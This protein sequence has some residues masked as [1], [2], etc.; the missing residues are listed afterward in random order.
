MTLVELNVQT[1]SMVGMLRVGPVLGTEVAI[2]KIGSTLTA[3]I[4]IATV[5]LVAGD[6]VMGLIGTR[7][8]TGT[9][10]LITETGVTSI[11][12]IQD[13]MHRGHPVRGSIVITISGGVSSI[14]D[15]RD[16]A[17]GINNPE[18]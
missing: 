8:E 3:E 13:I 1:N 16:M 10:P 7:E 4:L 18:G 17:S 14:Q 2:R 12:T 11:Q 6:M 15:S 5:A 9:M